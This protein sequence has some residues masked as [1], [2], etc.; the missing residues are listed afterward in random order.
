MRSTTTKSPDGAWCLVAA[1]GEYFLKVSAAEHQTR[2]EAVSVTGEKQD[3]IKVGL[4]A[5]ADSGPKIVISKPELDSSGVILFSG[6]TLVIEGVVKGMLAT[7]MKAN[8]AAVSVA[9]NA[10][11]TTYP[12]TKNTEITLKA[13]GLCGEE[14]TSRITVVVGEEAVLSACGCA[15]G[16]EGLAL[17][18]LAGLV[19][20]FVRRRRRAG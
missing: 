9:K 6:Q 19:S 12:I 16:G 4:P 3:D 7:N 2:Y 8:D 20:T 1:A 15:S 10:F 14:A 18:G 5:G 11:S 13:T 17:I